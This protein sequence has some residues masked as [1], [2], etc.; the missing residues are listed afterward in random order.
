MWFL[1]WD[2]LPACPLLQDVLVTEDD[3]AK[4]AGVQKEMASTRTFASNPTAWPLRQQRPPSIQSTLSIQSTQSKTPRSRRRRSDVLAPAIV[5]S[6]LRSDNS[7]RRPSPSA[8]NSKA[9][10]LQAHLLMT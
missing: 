3:F 5:R 8:N 4:A 9:P 7:A 10:L 2:R 1:A 6:S